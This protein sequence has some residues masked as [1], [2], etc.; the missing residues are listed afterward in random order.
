MFF[1]PRV[2]SITADDLKRELSGG[3]ATL[4]DVRELSEFSAGHVPGAISMPLGS[5]PQAASK[6]FASDAEILV[7]CQSGRRSVRATKR[8]MK[9][10]FTN[11]RN[12][13]GGTSAWSGQL[14]R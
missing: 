8:L 3:S 7:I 12:V 2:L 1:G 14:K 13:A 10:G 5:L 6:R 9:A 11:V 4:I